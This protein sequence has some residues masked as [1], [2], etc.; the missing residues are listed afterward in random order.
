[1]L[2][3]RVSPAACYPLTLEAAALCPPLQKAPAD[4]E[5][6]IAG[7]SE[8]TVRRLVEYLEF[9]KTGEHTPS[10][11]QRP[12]VSSDLAESGG[13]KFDCAFADALSH[14]EVKE[15]LQVAERLELPALVE[16]MAACIARTLRL[17]K[18]SGGL[19]IEAGF[20]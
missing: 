18:A 9:Y 19:R 11:F 4:T 1:M 3:L 13:T 12:L 14:D 2:H 20:H 16:L 8:S 7:A 17:W 5:I 15:L 6:A 10:T